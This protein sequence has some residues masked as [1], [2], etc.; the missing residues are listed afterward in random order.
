M[1]YRFLLLGLATAALAAC[2]TPDV[3]QAQAV[4][5]LIPSAGSTVSGDVKFTQKSGGKVVVSAVV[6]GLA[7]NSEHGFHIHENGNCADNG[8]AAGGH[9]TPLKG[10]HGKY[11]AAMHHMGDLPSL[12]A[13]SNGVATVNIES[14][15]LTLLAGP[16][17]IIDRG[18][19]VHAQADDYVTQPTG[20]AGARLACAVIERK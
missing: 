13:D 11:D 15:D 1:Q 5:H 16:G 17:N 14:S 20:N 2:S 12:K 10:N 18:L 7:P 19:I 4:G 6:R 8:N 9:F 3:Q